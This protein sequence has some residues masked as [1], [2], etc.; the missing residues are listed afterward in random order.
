MKENEIY[1]IYELDKISFF[2]PAIGYWIVLAIL[3]AV[4]SLWYIYV[5]Y[6]N[7]KLNSWRWQAKKNLDDLFESEDINVVEL[8]NI[9]KKIL[10]NLYK[11]DDIANLSGVE[12]LEYLQK[13]DKNGFDWVVNG[14]ILVKVFAPNKTIPNSENIKNLIKEI[15]LWL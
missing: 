12:L 3:I 6:R 15:R 10:I 2:P 13:L 14:A 1:D 7:K 5:K 11:R 8:H 4:V 9:I